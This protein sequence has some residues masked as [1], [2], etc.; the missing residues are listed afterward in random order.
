MQVHGDDVGN[1]ADEVL[2]HTVEDEHGEIGAQAQ[3]YF[4]KQET[5]QRNLPTER[6]WR[7]LVLHSM[8]CSHDNV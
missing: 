1:G 3:N 4:Q 2:F 6:A 8:L 5:C 7:H